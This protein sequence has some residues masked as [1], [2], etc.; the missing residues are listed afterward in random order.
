VVQFAWNAYACC[1][2]PG[3][4]WTAGNQSNINWELWIA[5]N[6]M[7]AGAQWGVYNSTSP[8]SATMSDAGSAVGGATVAMFFQAANAG[9]PQPA[10]I[11]VVGRKTININAASP[12]S[13]NPHTMQVPCPAYSNLLVVNYASGGEDLT[14]VS[15]NPSNTW[16]QAH[17]LVGT[18]TPRVHNYYAANAT[19]SPTTTVTLTLGSV[20]SQSAEIYCVKG[21]A[22]APFDVAA[23][24]SAGLQTSCPGGTCNLNLVTITPTTVN[25]LILVTG[26]QEQ[27]TSNQLVGASQLWDG[28]LYSAESLSVSGC[29]QNNPF[30]HY[31]N[32]NTSSVNFTATQL[33]NSL[34]VQDY[35]AEADAY[36]AA[37]TT[38]LQPPTGLTATV[39]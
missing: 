35:V 19:L 9:T 11:Q 38:T 5:E 16:V 13:A 14:G 7:A 15:S 27:N 33:S 2:T 23:V 24:N 20:S 17:A 18:G 31:L 4:T 30:G 32:P 28:C 8:L 37:G 10:G 12:F 3:I 34:P 22:T 25:G 26:S 29:S 1:S 36:K 39:Q 21:A 6:E